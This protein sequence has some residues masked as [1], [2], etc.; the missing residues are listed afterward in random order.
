MSAHGPGRVSTRTAFEASSRLPICAILR[1]TMAPQFTTFRRCT[2]PLS[3]LFSTSTLPVVQYAVAINQQHL[4]AWFDANCAAAKR[5]TRAFE[6]RYR[7]TRLVSDR[8]AWTTQALKKHRLYGRKHS[9][10][11]ERRITDSRGDPKKLWRDLKS[12][13]RQKKEKP[14]N[15]EELT[16]KA[17][18]NAFAEKLAGMRSSTASAAPPVFDKPPCTSI[19]D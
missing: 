15:S 6:Q 16:A 1:N 19:S 10:F 3:A 17:F 7:R 4:G 14:P 11:W 5:R 12:V 18:S 8:L 2:T 9:E 13:L